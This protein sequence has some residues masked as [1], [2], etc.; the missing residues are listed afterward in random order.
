MEQREIL[1]KAKTINEPIK[2]IEGSLLNTTIGFMIVTEEN[3]LDGESFVEL[4]NSIRFQCEAIR[5]NPETICQFLNKKFIK[6][7]PVY[8]NDI[9]FI[10]YEE[11]YGDERMYVVATY[12]KELG[13]HAFL[14]SGE[15]LDYSDNGIKALDQAF[16][17]TY[18]LENSEK[19]HYAGNMI[20]NPKLI[21]P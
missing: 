13:I 16:M 19:Y 2:W 4:K 6:G 20:D 21:N 15:Y 7:N 14:N 9:G 8:E 3:R 10:E 11:D 18:G 17:N 5:I 12:I 1:F